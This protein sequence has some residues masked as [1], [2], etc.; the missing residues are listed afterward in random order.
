MPSVQ[1]RFQ[2]LRGAYCA[3]KVRYYMHYIRIMTKRGS[4]VATTCVLNRLIAALCKHYIQRVNALNAYS[5]PPPALAAALVTS[6]ARFYRSKTLLHRNRK[7]QGNKR[8]GCIGSQPAALGKSQQASNKGHPLTHSTHSIAL[9]GLDIQQRRCKQ[10][11][12]GTAAAA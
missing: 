2:A 7:H 12:I 8:S 6:A 10:G 3:W 5:G 4:T 11:H 9:C 1:A